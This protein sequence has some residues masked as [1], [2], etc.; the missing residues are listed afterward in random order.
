MELKLRDASVKTVE[1]VVKKNFGVEDI[2]DIE[3]KSSYRIDGLQKAADMI[4]EAIS[5]KQLITIVG[6]YDADGV[7]SSSIMY[8]TLSYLGAIVRVRIPKRLSEGFGLN[9]NII[10]EIDSGLVITVDNGIVAFDPIKKAKEL[11]LSV[12]VTDHHLPAED[13]T[14]PEADLII[15][16]HL[17]GTADFED[18]CGAGIAFR[19]AKELVNDETVI[20][21]MSAFAAI[22]TIADVMPLVEENRQIVKMGLKNMTTYGCRTSGL[23]SVLKAVDMDKNLSA[24]DVAFKIGPMINAVGRLFDDGAKIAFESLVYDDKFDESIGTKLNEYNEL[25]KKKVE[26]GVK[27]VEKNIKDNC[28]FGDVP[29]IVYE[30]SIEEGIVGIIA[31]KLAEKNNVPSFV[32]TNS[33]EPGIYKGSGRTGGQVHLK[34]LLDSCAETVYKYGGHA[35]AAG[36]SV[37]AS[38]FSE[39]CEKMQEN[40]PEL[41]IEEE[42]SICYYDLEINASDIKATVEELKKYEPYGQGNPKPVFYIKNFQMSPRYGS[43]YKT[44]GKNGEHLKL[45]GIGCSAI[46][47][48]MVEEYHT[49]GDPNK[50]DLVGVISENYFMGKADIQVEIQAMDSALTAFSKSILAETLETM[51]KTRY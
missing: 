42:N 38:K 6:D 49:L 40:C 18:Y 31:G 37:E 43:L 11:G 24:T 36:V 1:D 30:P 12:I 3:G 10:D 15:D 4:K 32:F 22:G 13:G 7:T 35:E 9:M 17:P 50:L 19:L 14:L 26:D 33:E 46:G 48:G 23:Y 44:L 45:F 2:K 47:F 29:L 39:F 8:Y 34:D 20:N 21:K 5:K 28:L 27:A 25:R 16:P 41:V 51:A